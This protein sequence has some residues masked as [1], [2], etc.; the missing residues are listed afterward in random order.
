MVLGKDYLLKLE[1]FIVIGENIFIFLVG[2]LK[3]YDTEFLSILKSL[4]K[5]L[6]YE[7]SDSYNY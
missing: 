1:S 3:I 5:D 4:M 7:N 2:D 6:F